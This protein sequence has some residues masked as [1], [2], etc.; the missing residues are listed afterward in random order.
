MT[1]KRTLT[2]P[3]LTFYGLGTIIGAGIYALIG[4]VTQHAGQLTPWSF[5]IAGLVAFF[6]AASYAELSS[7]FPESAGSALYVQKAFK[8]T[9]LSGLVGWF[10]VFTGVVSAA[11]LTH[12]FINYFQLFFAFRSLLFIPALIIILGFIAVLGITESVVVIM[13]MTIVE[14]SGLL[15]IVWYGKS[16]FLEFSSQF[17]T[18]LPTFEWQAW[19]GIFTGAFIAFYAFIGFEDMVNVA[20]ET[21]NPQ[22]TLPSA[23]FT[24]LFGS[25]FLY[26]IVAIVTITALPLT[27]LLNSSVPLTLIIKA[28]GHSP[29][30]FGFIAILAIVNGILVQIIMASRLI[31]GMARY[32]SAPQ[33]FSMI[34]KKTQT[35]LVATL[36]VLLAIIILAYLF[37]IETLAKLTS[38]VMLLVFSIMHLSLLV[39]KMRDGKFSEGLSLPILMPSI[40]L[41]LT[42]GFILLQLISWLTTF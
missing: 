23:I 11:T 29:I 5:L 1:L 19:Q 20:E 41:M 26:I 28:Q 8:K 37:P 12:G 4:N 21:I 22:K 10:I 42:L 38:S 2:Y 30:L 16:G 25:T 32:K 13:L 27:E 7:R 9:W 34:Y 14:I 39:I 31:Y 6:T 3:L 24:A 40:G 36:F 35:P 18:Y 33:I 17:K 15:L